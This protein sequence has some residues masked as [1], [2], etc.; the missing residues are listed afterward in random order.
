MDKGKTIEK[1]LIKKGKT[2]LESSLK[3]V[4]KKLIN[5]MLKELD[6]NNITE[7]KE[8][9]IESFEI[10]VDT[11]KNDFFTKMFFSRLLANENSIVFIPYQSDIENFNVFVY[12]KDN[13]YTYYIPKEL[14]KIIKEKF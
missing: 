13:H 10:L 2:D 4:D 12:E 9:I 3:L 14:K 7:L 1:Y 6:L 11:A 5:K 8:Y